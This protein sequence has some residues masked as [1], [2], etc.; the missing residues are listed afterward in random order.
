MS[1]GKNAI[2]RP[3]Q[4]KALTHGAAG[5]AQRDVLKV[6][7]VCEILEHPHQR[8]PVAGRELR[9]RAERASHRRWYFVRENAVLGTAVLAAYPVL[10]ARRM[11]P[12]P[13]GLFGFAFIKFSRRGDFGV[14][15]GEE[16]R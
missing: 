15:A 16:R 12:V 14:Q 4:S 3:R 5:R 6:G 11:L 1:R 2:F 9:E 7:Y 10:R 8:T 13:C